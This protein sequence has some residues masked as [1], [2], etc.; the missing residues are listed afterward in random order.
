MRMYYQSEH[1]L[2]DE[3]QPKFKGDD[4][5]YIIVSKVTGRSIVDKNKLLLKMTYFECV[6]MIE[7][8]EQIHHYFNE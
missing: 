5:I 8:I 6:R 4:R 3:L 7:V 1:F 2:I